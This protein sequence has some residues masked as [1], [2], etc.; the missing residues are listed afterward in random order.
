MG[1]KR[2][3]ALLVGDNPFH[4]ISHWSQE[5]AKA[6]G[7]KLKDPEYAADLISISVDNGANGFM[8]SVSETTLSILRVLHER[9]EIGRLTF[10]A[11]VP[12]AFEYVRLAN[13]LGGVPGLAKKF[14]KEIV[15]SGNLWAASR[16]LKGVLCADLASIMKAYLSY[17]ISRITSSGGKKANLQSVMLHELITDM[18]LAFNLDWLFKAYIDFMLKCTVTPGFNTGNFAFLVKKFR[19]WNIDLKKITVAAPFNKV[20]FQMIPSKTECEKALESFHEPIVIAISILAAGYLQPIEAIDY[21][22]SL[23]NI[24]GV[25]VG[26]SREKHARETFSLINERLALCK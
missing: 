25:A 2:D 13:K 1:A 17:E 16:G 20:G 5:R 18:A 12:Y 23:P 24:R 14:A 11:I 8:F 10:Y 9:G 21:I 4:H 22:T 3:M 15:L 6:R 19:E 26:V 7:D